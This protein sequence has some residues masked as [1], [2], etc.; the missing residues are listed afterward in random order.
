MSTPVTP[1]GSHRDIPRLSRRRLLALASSAVGATI[2]AAC[3]GETAPSPTAAAPQATATRPPTQAPIVAAA[4][5]PATAPVATAGATGAAGVAPT[6]SAGTTAPAASTIPA[7]PAA[8]VAPAVPAASPTIA[9]MPG[10][11]GGTKTYKLALLGDLTQLDPALINSQVDFQVAEAIYNYIG[12]Y[13]YN[14]PLGNAVTPELAEWEVLDG[15]KTYI[16]HLKKG[17]KFHGGYGDLTAED[18]KYNWERIK[19]PKTASPY[20]TD[21]AGSTIEVLDPLTLK[22]SFDRPYPSFIGASLAF[23]PG[24]VISPKAFMEYGDRWKNKPIGSGPFVWDSY[25]AGSSLTL[26]RNPDYWGTKPKV[27]QI[28]YRFKVDDR[29]AVLAVAKGEIDAYYLADPDVAASVAKNPDPNT[30][31]LKS[32]FGQSPMTIWFNMKRKPLDDVRVRQ[33][34]RH[35]IDN[36]AIAK[37]L[38]GGLADP[39]NSFLPPFMF[40]FSDDVTR[41]DYNPDKARQ[42]LREANVSPDWSPSLLALSN[43]IIARRITEAVASYWTDAGIKVKAEILDQ[44]IINQRTTAGDYDMY[45][46]YVS[47][48]EPDQLATPFWSSGSSSNRSFYTGADDLILRAKAEPDLTKRAALYRELQDKISRDSP[49]AFVVAVSESLLVN[50]RVAG[51]AGAGWQERHDW[52]NVDV[53]AE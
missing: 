53:P 16:F 44:G 36:E 7:M 9:A 38:F 28:T 19:D 6:A 1:P 32:Q 45:G 37:N 50:K 35:A 48:I 30:R 8:S 25:Q 41:F 26:K 52:F 46:T 21:F 20:R 10:R 42:L 18:I 15:A 2:L 39:I 3:G 47:R 51:I 27:D 12:R 49:A 29:A 5:T 17:V 33:A 23:R 14:P 31:F 4:T 43:L 24:F 40:G 11:A 13:S 22:V 34:L